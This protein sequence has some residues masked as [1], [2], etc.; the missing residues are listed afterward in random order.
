MNF[1][2]KSALLEELKI[3]TDEEGSIAKIERI[4]NEW[5]AIGKVPKEKIAINREFNKVLKE[6]L[7]LNNISVFDINETSLPEDKLTEK[8][9]KIKKQIADLEAEVVKM[10]NNINFFNNATRENPLLQESFTKIDEK[11]AQIEALKK[12][13]HN[14]I[15][16]D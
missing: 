9:R 2:A 7:K 16:G 11:K 12:S 5:N 10:E 14:I 3:L 13:L 8:A 15:S 1:K 4:K 6:K